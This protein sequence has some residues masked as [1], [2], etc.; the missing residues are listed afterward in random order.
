MTVNDESMPCDGLETCSGCIPLRVLGLTP[1]DPCGANT[2]TKL[3]LQ[4]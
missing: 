3:L 1:I 2:D 4:R